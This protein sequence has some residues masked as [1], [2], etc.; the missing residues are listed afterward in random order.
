MRRHHKIRGVPI[1][2]CSAEQ[3]IA[4]NIAFYGHISLGDEYRNALRVSKNRADQILNEIIDIE[5]GSWMRTYSPR[6]NYDDDAI[7]ECLIAGLADY[8]VRPFIA[9]DYETVGR[10]FPKG[11]GK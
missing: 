11:V 9:S 10:A 6:N 2:V 8:L 5:F 4:Y 3:K 1:E 7:K